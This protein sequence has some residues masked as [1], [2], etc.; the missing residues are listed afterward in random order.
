MPGDYVVPNF[1]GWV[2]SSAQTHTTA[3]GVGLR[4]S[5]SADIPFHVPD[6]S[7]LTRTIVQNASNSPP[8]STKVPGEWVGVQIP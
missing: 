4:V 8:G 2:V 1:A 7:E 6:S 3:S 5:S